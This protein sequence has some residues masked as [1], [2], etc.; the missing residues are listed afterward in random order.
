MLYELTVGTIKSL[1]PFAISVGCVINFK[2]S[3]PTVLQRF[4]AF[5]YLKNP[6]TFISASAFS[7][8]RLANLSSTLFASIF[9]FS[10]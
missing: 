6:G 10:S 4:I 3:Y 5:N 8:L 1:S 9:P 7:L 2:S